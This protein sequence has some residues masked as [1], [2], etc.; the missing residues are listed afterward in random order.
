MV[1]PFGFWRTNEPGSIDWFEIEEAKD[2]KRKQDELRRADFVCSRT[3]ILTG[4]AI[5]KRVLMN[6]KETWLFTDV[7]VEA[8]EWIRQAP[9]TV[10]LHPSDTRVVVSYASGM[11]KVAGRLLSTS[12]EHPPPLGVPWLFMLDD[13]P[14]TSSFTAA[15]LTVDGE[16][17]LDPYTNEY[18]PLPRYIELL[19][20]LSQSC[21][22]NRLARRPVP[23]RGYR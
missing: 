8:N 6:Q 9:L 21:D 2:A 20:R 3:A 11:V 13:L 19:E 15:E 5:S 12:T 7:D 18:I 23:R 4:R 22:I 17:V 14:G 10:P 16:R 1:L